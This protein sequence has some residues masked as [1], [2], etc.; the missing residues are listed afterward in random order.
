[1]RWRRGWLQPNVDRLADPAPLPG[2]RFGLT[3]TGDAYLTGYDLAVPSPPTTLV[4][5][6]ERGG[7]PV[8]Q[9]TGDLDDVRD[10]AVRMIEEAY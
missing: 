8:V 1:M 10:V 3:D 4:L 7:R 2:E 9:V 5:T 6:I